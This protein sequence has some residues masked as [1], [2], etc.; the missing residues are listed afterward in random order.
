MKASKKLEQ[1]KKSEAKN[2]AAIDRHLE[3]IKSAKTA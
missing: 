3:A 1:L 2:R